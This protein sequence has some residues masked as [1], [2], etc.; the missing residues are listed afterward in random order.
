[1]L[2]HTLKIGLVV[3]VLG[4]V[5]Q[6][7]H[8]CGRWGGCGWGGCGYGYGSGYGGWGY[9]GYGYSGYG[10]YGGWPWSGWGYSYNGMSPASYPASSSG[11]RSDGNF[12][13]GANSILLAVTVPADAAVFINDR[14]TTSVGDHREYTSNGLQPNALYVYRVRAEFVR[15]G[16]PVT[17]EKV[18]QLTAGQTSSLEFSSAPT[19]QVA[20]KAQ[21][22]QR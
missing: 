7:A 13:P 22:A 10:G 6:N 18:A 11:T 21:S 5:A 9:G 2:R 15:D 8:A 19:A 16:K 20:G 12:Q 17:V 3:A 4:L 1:M 14:P